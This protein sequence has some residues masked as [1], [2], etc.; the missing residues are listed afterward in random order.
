[1]CRAWVHLPFKLTFR[2][3]RFAEGDATGE[4]ID[5]SIPIEKKTT[6]EPPTPQGCHSANQTSLVGRLVPRSL[7]LI[8]RCADA[9]VY[10]RSMTCETGVKVLRI[11]SDCRRSKRA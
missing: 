5:V 10:V 1:M 6:E 3:I 2:N 9:A 4:A 7:C 11:S 8:L